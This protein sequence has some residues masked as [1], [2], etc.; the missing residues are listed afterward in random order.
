VDERF[1]ALFRAVR[2]DWEAGAAARLPV[3]AGLTPEQVARALYRAWLDEHPLWAPFVHVRAE[4]LAP[5]DSLAD[6]LDDLATPGA[7]LLVTGARGEIPWPCGVRGLR[8]AAEPAPPWTPDEVD[9]VL[10]AEPVHTVATDPALDDLRRSLLSHGRAA[11]VV[12]LEGPPGAG[13]RSLARWAHGVLDDRPLSEI[14]AEADARPVPG[15]W[16]IYAEVAE[17]DADRLHH[18]R[19]ALERGRVA[20]A[21]RRDGTAGLQRPAASAFSRIVGDSPALLRALDRAARAAR[22]ELPVLVLGETGAGKELFARAIH[23]ASGR[24]GAFHAIDVSTLN[25]QLVE[26]ELFGHAAGAFTGADR[27]R[28]GAV[29]SAEGGTLFLDELGNLEP[30]TQAKLLRLLQER[31]VQPVGSDETVTVDVRFVAATNAD[32]HALVRR[33]EFR[34]DLLHRLEA[35]T[36]DIPPLRERGDDVLTLAATFFE[37]ARGAGSSGPGWLDPD[38]RALLRDHAWPGNVRELRQ[39]MHVAAFECER[40]PVRPEHLGPL[41]PRSRRAVP[42]LTTQSVP[43]GERLTLPLPSTLAQRMTTVTLR[44]PSLVDRGAASVRQAVLHALDGHPIRADALRALVERPWRGNLPE[45][46][47]DV[48]ALARS[49]SGAIDRAAVARL[50]P[51]LLTSG[52]SRPIVVLWS[53]TLHDGEVVGLE[54]SFPAGGLLVGRV[55]QVAHLEHLAATLD[56]AERERI[57]DQISEIRR[58]TF[59]TPRCLAFPHLPFVS[60]AHALVT[61]DDD[62]FRV[63]GMPG[64]SLPVTVSRLDGSG[65]TPRAIGAGGTARAGE[66]FEMQIRADETSPTLQ[67]FFFAGRVARDEHGHEAALRAHDGDRPRIEETRLVPLPLRAAARTCRRK[68]LEPVDPRRSRA[69][70]PQRRGGEVRRRAVLGPC[71]RRSRAAPHRRAPRPA[72]GVRARRATEPVRLGAVRAPAERRA[73]RRPRATGAPCRPC[74]RVARPPPD[75]HP[76][77][78]AGHAVGSWQTPSAPRDHAASARSAEQASR[79]M[80]RARRRRRQR[81]T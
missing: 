33:G 1:D 45:L 57:L 16:Q 78:R 23:D 30:K 17:L 10:A 34:A 60:R 53:P 46:V 8:P 27:P 3:P 14:S 51:H 25:P 80:S 74:G 49:A 64:I 12:H 47:A 42:V 26:S 18:L 29:R 13:K 36:L 37:E 63:S 24:R 61:L 68:A 52:T 55:Q 59:A 77:R 39:V 22:T 32:L 62:G 79:A 66:A 9:A 41:A 70:G 6:V 56:G 76:A 11:S 5:R 35:V 7:W 21:A 72:R 31:T 15:Q 81:R 28:R 44:V 43:E 71:A 69:R 50:L 20:V 65:A 40:L 73:S 58:L 75:R 48:R 19:V 38:A 67:L 54:Q 4:L 2:R